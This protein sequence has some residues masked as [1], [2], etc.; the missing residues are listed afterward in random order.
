MHQFDN[1]TKF[2]PL[3]F[4]PLFFL[5]T[6]VFAKQIDG[7][8]VESNVS[9]NQTQFNQSKD[10]NKNDQ[11]LKNKDNS[12]NIEFK[13]G[14]QF[15]N[16]FYLGGTYLSS[17]K[18]HFLLEK[19]H[20]HVFNYKNKVS[21]ELEIRQ[22]FDIK[23]KSLTDFQLKNQSYGIHFGYNFDLDNP[24]FQPYIT[25]NLLKNKATMTRTTLVNRNSFNINANLE[26]KNNNLNQLYEARNELL[27]K[28]QAYLNQNLPQMISIQQEIDMQ[29]NNLSSIEEQYIDHIN[30]TTSWTNLD[31]VMSSN[32][33]TDNEKEKIK[34]RIEKVE[35]KNNSSAYRK[36]YDEFSIGLEF[37]AKTFITKDFYLNYS[38][39]YQQLGKISNVRLKQYG[40]KIGLGY[41]F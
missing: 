12:N 22:S 3:I 23:N 9:F 27:N 14:H 32:L 15:N 2:P 28:K 38:A 16:G 4:I 5:N 31:K 6:F 35:E 10:K 19:E 7:F 11:F 40:A 18:M 36:K 17:E 33:I 30:Q 8:Y 21:S 37:G 24:Y 34:N 26:D 25:V 1:K 20:Q 13:L 41:Y 39:Y 29:L